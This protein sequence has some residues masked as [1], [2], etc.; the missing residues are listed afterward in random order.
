MQDFSKSI[1]K[2]QSFGIPLVSLFLPSGEGSSFCVTSKPCYMCTPM[3]AHT[4]PHGRQSERLTLAAP[5]VGW[6]AAQ[7]KAISL[8]AN[9]LILQI[10]PLMTDFVN[11]LLKHNIHIE[12]CTW[13]RRLIKFFTNQTYS[14]NQHPDPEAENYAP[15][16]DAPT[17]LS[18]TAQP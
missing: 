16:S 3:C 8:H 14:Y 17:P 11:T 7:I 6:R 10:V 4:P 5:H 12:V 13:K 2:A 18:L 1:Q 9:H 15:L